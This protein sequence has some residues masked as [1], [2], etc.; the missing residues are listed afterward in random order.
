MV[1]L[2]LAAAVEIETGFGLVPCHADVLPR[3]RRKRNG[4]RTGIARSV[5]RA[6]YAE[7]DGIRHVP[8]ETLVAVSDA[9]GHE[10][11]PK[12][13]HRVRCLDPERDCHAGTERRAETVG[14]VAIH[15]KGA[16]VVEFKPVYGTQCP[17]GSVFRVVGVSPL[18]RRPRP[19]TGVRRLYAFTRPFI[20]LGG[21]VEKPANRHGASRAVCGLRWLVLRK[22]LDLFRRSGIVEHGHFVNAGVVGAFLAVGAVALSLP[23]ADVDLLKVAGRP[24]RDIPDFSSIDKECTG[25]KGVRAIWRRHDCEMMPGIRRCA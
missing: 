4:S 24:Q 21:R 1:S 10:I 12:M 23:C 6:V 13:T 11:A 3:I 5:I 7:P 25:A 16:S 20:A 8:L 18:V 15:S 9:E 2:P 22:P 19:R 17:W 14:R